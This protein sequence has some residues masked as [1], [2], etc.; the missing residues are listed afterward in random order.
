M[1]S[2]KMLPGRT[3]PEP[4]PLRRPA[5]VPGLHNTGA[6]LLTKFPLESKVAELHSELDEL[7]SI[8]PIRYT[9]TDKGVSDV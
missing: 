4:M 5:K 1:K 3:L 6:R 2:R 9:L 7:L 8:T